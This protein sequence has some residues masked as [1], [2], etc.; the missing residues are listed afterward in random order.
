MLVAALTACSSQP[1]PSPTELAGKGAETVPCAF[2]EAKKFDA[3]CVLD[4]GNAEGKSVVTLWHPDGGFRRLEVL[5]FGK[6][7]ASLDGADEVVGG[8]NG[9]EVEVSVGD[10]HYL[11]PAPAP[12]PANSP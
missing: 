1:A 5:D 6:R 4:R 2:G 9:R 12:A 8:P 7:Y 11:M 3:K 10:S